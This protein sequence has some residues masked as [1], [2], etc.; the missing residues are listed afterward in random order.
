MCIQPCDWT[1]VSTH[2]QHSHTHTLTDAMH[3]LPPSQIKKRNLRLP[4]R[5]RDVPILQA[6]FLEDT[7]IKAKSKMLEK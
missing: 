4:V 3:H 7:M 2:I 6:G 5:S 1:H